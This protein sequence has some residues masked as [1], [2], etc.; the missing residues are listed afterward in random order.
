MCYPCRGCWTVETGA[1]TEARLCQ[2][3]VLVSESVCVTPPDSA[4]AVCVHVNEPRPEADDP[5]S[6][7]FPEPRCSSGTT[8]PRPPDDPERTPTSEYTHTTTHEQ[9]NTF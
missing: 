9:T 4:P 8:T 2:V 7:G 5:E 1:G 6:Q 3:C